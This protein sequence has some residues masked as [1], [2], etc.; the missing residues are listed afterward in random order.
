MKKILAALALI[1]TCQGTF[2][3]NISELVNGQ[4]G[5]KHGRK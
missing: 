4:T 3:Q 5:K 1:M 2:A